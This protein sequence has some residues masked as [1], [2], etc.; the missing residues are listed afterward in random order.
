MANEHL[1]SKAKMALH[2]TGAP[3]MGYLLPEAIAGPH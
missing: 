1:T 2:F 3:T